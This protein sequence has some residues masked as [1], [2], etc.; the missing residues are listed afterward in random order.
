MILSASR[1]FR[2]F[3]IVIF[4]VSPIFWSTSFHVSST[5]LV[6]PVIEK[7]EKVG[8]WGSVKNEPKIPY[9]VLR[10]ILEVFMSRFFERLASCC[11]NNFRTLLVVDHR[12]G[13][14]LLL[15]GG[16]YLSWSTGR[17]EFVPSNSEMKHVSNIT[18]INIILRS[19]VVIMSLSSLTTSLYEQWSR[20]A[21]RCFTLLRYGFEP[22]AKFKVCQASGGGV[23]NRPH[24]CRQRQ[25]AGGAPGQGKVSALREGLPNIEIA[26]LGGGEGRRA[27]IKPEEGSRTH[28]YVYRAGN[29]LMLVQQPERLPMVVYFTYCITTHEICGL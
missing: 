11:S 29:L 9:V 14:C 19:S 24:H 2:S 23:Q 3:S 21:N 25:E 5:F 16:R 6:L 18:T 20:A 7:R 28:F 17:Q 13:D 1:C 8:N 22:R 10:N 27:V 12:S 4:S 26:K 15:C